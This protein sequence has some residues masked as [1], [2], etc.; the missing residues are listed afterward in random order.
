MFVKRTLDSILPV[1]CRKDLFMS[2]FNSCE[3]VHGD[4]EGFFAELARQSAT[5]AYLGRAMICP[6]LVQ[7]QHPI[8]QG[9][10]VD[11]V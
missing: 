11:N 10:G 4:I 7:M 3:L 1:V 9:E 6:L 5:F 8:L 2:N